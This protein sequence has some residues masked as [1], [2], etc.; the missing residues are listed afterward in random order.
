MKKQKSIK[1]KRFN[2]LKS[3]CLGGCLLSYA[4]ETA[5]NLSENDSEQINFTVKMNNKTVR[6]VFSHIEKNSEFIIIYQ[7]TQID[8]DRKVSINL[9]DQ[10]VQE[11]LREIFAGTN[12]TYSIK[13]RQIIVKKTPTKEESKGLSTNQQ[14]KTVI[15]LLTDV[16]GNPVIGATVSIKGTTYGVTTDIDG[17][18]ILN[19]INEGDVINFRYIGYNTEE[20]TYK[21]EKNINIR[22]TESSVGLEDVVVIGYGQQKKE[23]VV[24]SL[25]TIGTAELNVKQRN[26]RNAL[27]G[28]IAGVIAVQRSG[29]PGNDAAAFYIRGQSSYAGGT[30]ALVLVDGVPRNMDDIDVDEI[31][32]FT[33]LKDAAATAVYGAEG[34][35]GVVLIT[36][37]RGKTQKTTVNFSA[38]YSLVTPT[39]MPETLNSY[40]YLSLYNE[41]LWNDQGN[42]DKEFF[43]P[44][45]TDDHLNQFRNGSDPD[46][47]PSVNWYDLLQD[48]T[49]SQRYTVNFRGGSDKVRFF[50]SG[51]YYSEDGIFKSNPMEK[52]DAN[53]G[54][55]RFNLRS[56]VDMDLTKTTQLSIDM[57]G[58]YL[59]KNQPGYSTNEIF[60]YIS[61]FPV[62]VIPMYYSDNT[63]SD[64][65]A[66]GGGVNYQPYN[67]LNNSG[68]SKTWSAFLQTKVTLKQDLKFITEGLSVKGSVS[69]DADF[70]STMKRSKTPKS[71][72]TLGRNEDGTLNKK[73]MKEG[74][75]LGNPGIS[76]HDGTKKIYMEASVDYQHTFNKL[77]DVSGMLLYMQ[78]ETQYQNKDG[79]QLLPYRKQSFVARATYGYDSRYMV[80]AS[81]GMTGSENFAQ[82][83][84]WGIFPAVGAAWFVSHEKFMSGL[85]DHIS[86]LKLRISYGITGN[87]NI[88]DN[89]R[90]P[91]R[92]SI[93]MGLGGYNFG[94]TPGASG[95]ASNSPGKGIAEGGF[96]MPNLSWEIENKLNAGIDIGLFRGRVD[97]S[98]DYF[99]NRRSEILLQRRTVSNV[100]G[101]R[102]LPYQNFGI[103]R[104][105]GVDANLILKQKIGQVD[106]SARGNLTFAQNKILEYDEVPQKYTYQNYTGHSIFGSNPDKMKLYIAE[107]LYMPEDFDITSNNTGAKNYTLK[108]GMPIPAANVAPGD[109]KYK[110]LNNDGAIDDYDRTF[111]HG[112][113]PE[114][115]EIV[116]GFGLNAEW[117]G[118]F[119][120]VFFQ[121]TAHTSANM[122]AE[123]F[124]LMPFTQGIDNGSARGETKDRWKAENPSNQDVFFPR[125]HTGRFDH[126]QY[127]STYWFRDAGFLR[128][129]NI[130]IGYEFNDKI[131]KHLKMKNLRVY[132]QGNNVAVWDKIK[133]WDPELGNA[134]SGAKY[135]ICSTY[136][137]GLEV[138]F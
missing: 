54:L 137:V 114:V 87:D 65:P 129:K 22:M 77:H 61:H 132:L 91:Y 107:G 34:A 8:L 79:L 99:Y 29:E 30:S 76:G 70:Y 33:V 1:P 12:D 98:A 90:F 25:N 81:M 55:Q 28:Q 9:N 122:L 41:T 120:G 43:N 118:F 111:N 21:G 102:V 127:A 112:Y 2:Y 35:N 64:H 83:H 93:N 72:Y 24:S 75:A 36:S 5:A 110:D 68:Y 92:E 88:G 134:D 19:N 4:G 52:Y 14:K 17:K 59:K 18:Y 135:P 84:R 50:A 117:K 138:T 63:A 37:K 57:S 45:Y 125:L 104:N 44:Q 108:N 27:A 39:R 105:Q 119:V 136:S 73:T 16:D 47:Y 58:Q 42:P 115:P 86:K 11:I 23:S 60:N 106:L 13:G 10:P 7:G 15:G 94:L 66:P 48:H 121:G 109:I 62:H 133:F 53:I 80:E 51:A 95:S 26:L 40:D 101:F 128:L 89:T 74:S 69:F 38:Q 131:L 3:I 46:L 123:Y 49:Q 124:N 96:P 71:F 100:T 6:D 82:G 32:S 78:K 116:Y 97:F 113:S 130:E 67:M 126:N 31:E 85:E 56:N 20:K 103:V